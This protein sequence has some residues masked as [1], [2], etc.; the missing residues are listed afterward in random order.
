MAGEHRKAQARVVVTGIDEKGKSTIVSDGPTPVRLETPGMTICDLWEVEPPVERGR[1]ERVER[2]R[3]PRSG[4]DRVRH[5][6][7]H[8]RSR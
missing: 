3:S 1:Q 8:V 4:K 6:G 7:H 5:A 2:R